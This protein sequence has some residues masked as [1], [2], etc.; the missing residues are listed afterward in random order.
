MHSE[1]AVDAYKAA[2]IEN[3]PPLKILRM[4]YQGALRFIDQA[5]A[6]DPKSDPAAFNAKVGRV[7]DI[8]TELRCCLNHEPAPEL[9]RQ[10]EA[11]YEFSQERLSRAVTDRSVEPL[12]DA[13]AVLARLLEG[14]SAID[15]RGQS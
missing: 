9:T 1:S 3:A 12:A 2:A 5:A 4:L 11:L 13:R 8:L 7:D 10:L 6:M 14:W 15:L